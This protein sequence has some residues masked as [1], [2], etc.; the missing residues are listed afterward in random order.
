LI[1]TLKKAIYRHGY[2]IITA[3]WLYTISFIFINYWNYNASPQKVK[4]RL[5][6][7]LAK[8]EARL[9]ELL[10][11][12]DLL[13]KLV[14][15]SADEQSKQK[16][17]QE[18]FGLFLYLTDGS[19]TPAMHYWN[20]NR[21]YVNS[22][23]LHQPDG[24]YFSVK[25]NGDF[26]LIK[27]TVQLKGQK[28][29]VLGLVPI[30]WAYFIEN[31]YLKSDF[32][33]YPGLGK[34]Y[35]I[36]FDKDAIPILNSAGKEI[37]SI[38]MKVGRS[39]I[40]YDSVT[41]VLRVLAVILLL[42]FFNMIAQE[43]VERIGFRSGFLFLLTVVFLIRLITYQVNFPLDYSKLPLFDPTIY[44]S[45]FLHPSLGDLLVNA[46]LL[47]WMLSFYKFHND[48]KGW[49]KKSL[50][51]PVR[52]YGGL[53]LLTVACLLLA[54][55][56]KSLVQD[57]KISMDVTS[58]FSLTIYSVI[59]FV[60][61]C[62]L[63][64]SFYHFSQIV[65]KPLTDAAVPLYYQMAAVAITGFAY[66]LAFVSLNDIAVDL[67]ILA[68]LIAYLLLLNARKADMG[69]PLLQ[70][71]FFIFWVMIFTLSISAIVMYQN[72]V[73]ESA[74]RKKIAEQL[75]VQTDPSGE[76]LLN[77]AANS[78]NERFLLNNFHRFES[79]YTNKFIKDSLINQNFSGYLNKYDTRIYTYDSLF[80]PLYN[81]DST[82]YA[83]IKTIIL[84]KS[85]PTAIEG[86]YSYDNAANGFSYL[87]QK[88][89]K[90]ND[91][92][93][94]YLYVTIKSRRYKSEALYPELFSQSQD[95]SSDLN[96]SYAYAIYN[97]GK[98]INH[99]N[100]YN[101]PLKLTRA[102][103]PGLDFTYK[104]PPGFSELWYNTGGDKEV[105]V[106]KKS[107]WFTEFITFFAYLFCSFLC[108]I[109]LFHL[110]SNLVRARFKWSGIRSIFLLNIRSQIQATIIFLSVFSFLVIGVSTISFFIFRFN[111]NNEEKLSKSILVMAN[112]INNK[113][114]PQLIFDDV[115]NTSNVSVAGDQLNEVISDI[116]DLHN[117]DINFYDVNGNL[118][119]STQPYIYNKRLLSE[120]MD[121]AAFQQMHDE[122]SIRYIQSEKIGSFEYLS[123]YV[124]L[125]DEEGA[126]YAYLNIPYLNSQN[127]LDQ[128]I[129]GFL[130]TLIYLNAFIFLV[131]GAIA[132][133]LTS[134]ITDSFNLI[135]EKM[136]EVNLGKTNEEIQWDRDD[137]LGMLVSEYNKM[138][139][140]L[141]Q[142]AQSLAKSER[143]GAWREMARQVAHEIKN[144]LTPMKLSIQYLQKA[145][146]SDAPNVKELSANMA[147][148]LIEQIDQLSK[149]AGDFSQFANIGNARMEKLDI[150]EV[151]S[152][153]LR[154]YEANPRVKIHW[155]K[156][157][158]HYLVYSDKTQMNRLFT[159]LLQNAIEAK[160]D[161]GS[162][163][164]IH[165]NQQVE[166]GQL[167]ISVQDNSG[168][169]PTALRDDIFTP[170][171]TTKSSGTGLGLAIC[172]GIV[173]NAN[174]QIWFETTEGV[175]ST[176]FVQLPVIATSSSR[177]K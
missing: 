63:V 160:E 150:M 113:M 59:C 112:E 74:Q 91:Q 168:G 1:R 46:I 76:S 147:I 89:I 17:R 159:N 73:L 71:S 20:T 139:K 45:N 51:P 161:P 18:S 92:T 37:F 174:G 31:K 88:A 87:Y 50:P 145:I 78:F 107:A 137:E 148:T 132:F 115:I 65:V 169:V 170:N 163:I 32:A 29:T 94:G 34:Q 21:M 83:A 133:F 58:F 77:I 101:F 52:H 70:S 6:E 130:A 7:S 102:E 105:V 8:Q 131:A 136:R 42:V 176:F 114:T 152:S 15:D 67:V 165:I 75:A 86:L 146:Q 53:A 93:L 171:F 23:D 66:L 25:Q 72:K 164:E 68:W 60:I 98:L 43:L 54:G 154:L 104:K 122:H 79:E 142:S 48:H 85:K 62:L 33:H 26:E 11:E 49:F 135:G 19:G 121:P 10:S 56:I 96:T 167:L 124:P 36:N 69:I 84:N 118:K 24:N 47:F 99:F 2:L 44:A 116:S 16:I 177:T 125:M 162:K 90:N 140:E 100:N 155:K 153:L 57:S 128:E 127:E 40:A 22:E 38:K 156:P 110:C 158:E 4:H 143:E 103:M 120:Q 80:H 119:V 13:I 109:F 149:I 166:S 129:S 117:V 111:N 95:I 138:V 61:L 39:F 134:R 14:K 41:I 55:I 97:R 3:A 141:D 28:L 151:L 9:D 175:G 12:K 64:L 82:S 123:I 108:I 173:E 126:T 30:R 157:S 81:E 35:E 172:R 106:V 144:P 27:R 5:E